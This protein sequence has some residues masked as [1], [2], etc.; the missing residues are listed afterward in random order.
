MLVDV[1]AIVTFCCVERIS[2]PM[3]AEMP[4]CRK[5]NVFM[6]CR[7]ALLIMPKS[8]QPRLLS[9]A[10]RYRLLASR[11]ADFGHSIAACEG[12]RKISSRPGRC[13]EKSIVGARAAHHA[14]RPSLLIRA[15]APTSF[16]FRAIAGMARCWPAPVI[17]EIRVLTMR[18]R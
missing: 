18:R 12:K 15:W 3:M 10:R 2:S 16:R 17:D 7:H 13:G 9:S 1:P 8:S 11:H 14:R 4:L 6:I 5:I